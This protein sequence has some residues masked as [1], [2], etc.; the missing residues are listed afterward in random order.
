MFNTDRKRRERIRSKREQASQENTPTTQNASP[1][2]V[3]SAANPATA[4]D[5]HVRAAPGRTAR[6]RRRTLRK[7]ARS[8]ATTTV[9]SEAEKPNWLQHALTDRLSNKPR[10]LREKRLHRQAESRRDTKRPEARVRPI[11]VVWISWRW[12]SGSL[13]LFLLV[14]LYAMLGSQAFVVNTIAV[15]GERYVSPEWVF[16]TT[17]IAGNN[18]FTVDAADV[19]SRLERDPSVADAQVYVSWPP[20]AVSVVVAERDPA[21]VWDQGG[22][23][24]WVDINGIV[25]FQRE[26]RADLIRIRHEDPDAEPLGVGNTIDREIVAGALQLHA[27]L[28]SIKTF[29]Y[30]PV[31]GIGFFDERN[32]RAWFG[33]GTDMERRLR[34]YDQ[35]VRQ[36][37]PTI[38]FSEI[39]V[40]NADYPVFV[41]RY[42]AEQPA[43]Q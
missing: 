17:K 11:G 23:R 39:D 13:S 15:G 6:K 24:V 16:N 18:L 22:F 25:M 12:L 36:N 4:D 42:P 10:T 5:G 1:T 14:I 28:P 20:N 34:I 43:E 35:I 31:K 3:L 21:M 7:E 8:T 38:S 26:E 40:S 41:D 19:E 27:K 32:W 2:S 37:Y 9:S 29:L 33:V 30:D